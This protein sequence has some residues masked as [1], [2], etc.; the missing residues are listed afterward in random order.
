MQGPVSEQVVPGGGES[1]D[2]SGSVHHVDGT[3]LSL[4]VEV[5]KHYGP[6]LT[7]ECWCLVPFHCPGLL[8][9]LPYMGSSAT[10]IHKLV[11]RLT[12]EDRRV[13]TTAMAATHSHVSLPPELV[14]KIMCLAF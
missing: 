10:G 12:S 4:M 2:S 3:T 11:N 14:Q 13:L 1:S 9:A 5:V 8:S 6:Y 7:D